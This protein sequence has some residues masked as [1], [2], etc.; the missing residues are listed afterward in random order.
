MA[1]SADG[2]ARPVQ[3]PG[4]LIECPEC[5]LRLGLGVLPRRVVA[6]C[7]RCGA[8]LR[9][10]TSL[11]ACLA[12][13]LT[14]LVLIGLA[15]F[16]PFMSFGMEGRVQDASLSTGA[17][18]LWADGLWP[19]GLLILLLTIVVPAVKLGALA[20]VLLRAQGA[21]IRRAPSFRCCAGSISSARGRW[22]RSICS[23]SSSPM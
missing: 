11:D 4:R 3:R 13:A 2:S 18:G 7:G 10:H 23:A 19:L 17:L 8:L 5:G 12:L 14:G 15:N 1:L 9:G 21:R 6:R 22:S 16:M 20:W